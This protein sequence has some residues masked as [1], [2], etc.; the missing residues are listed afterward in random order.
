MEDLNTSGVIDQALLDW[1]TELRIL[2]NEAAHGDNET[3]R[4]DAKDA[5]E[6]TEAMLSY[7]YTY[8]QNFDLFKRR[9]DANKEIQKKSH[10]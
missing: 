2:G 7:I 6:F 4:Q 1:A 3:S 10:G 9:R 5:L 8:R